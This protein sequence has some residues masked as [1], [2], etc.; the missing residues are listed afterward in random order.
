MRAHKESPAALGDRASELL[1][2]GGFEHPEVT[3]SAPSRQDVIEAERCAG[4]SRRHALAALAIGGALA[5]QQAAL[6]TH[7]AGRAHDLTKGTSR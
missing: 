4:L 1:C 6:A 7:Y 2:F 3:R 5:I